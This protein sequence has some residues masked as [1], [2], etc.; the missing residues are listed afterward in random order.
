[1]CGAAGHNSDDCR[2]LHAAHLLE[3]QPDLLTL[4][5][6]DFG[7]EAERADSR[8]PWIVS[9]IPQYD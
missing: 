2:W 9:P 3:S 8:S 1:M 7:F 6:V 4:P 5:I